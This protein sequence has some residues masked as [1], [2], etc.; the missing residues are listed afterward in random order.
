MILLNKSFKLSLKGLY[1]RLFVYKL[2]RNAMNGVCQQDQLTW[3][4]IHSE[5]W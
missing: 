5:E 3:N 4:E 1:H 2:T